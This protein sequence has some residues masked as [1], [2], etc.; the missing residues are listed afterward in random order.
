MK[1]EIV[2]QDLAR[3]LPRV[4]GDA[5]RRA[6]GKRHPGAG[7]GAEIFFHDRALQKIARGESARS[8]A[9]LNVRPLTLP[10][11]MPLPSSTS[12]NQQ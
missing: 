10:V 11:F 4:S 5:A 7:R 3:A 1:G 8:R 2:F 12:A 6:L 9:G